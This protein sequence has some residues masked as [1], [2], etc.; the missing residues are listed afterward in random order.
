MVTTKVTDLTHQIY[1]EMPVY[2][3]TELPSFE[4]VNTLEEHG[5]IETRITITSHTGTHVDAPAHMINNGCTLDNIPIE[6]FI[7][8]AIILDFSNQNLQQIEVSDLK[9]F[10]TMIIN[11][12]NFIII[13]TGWSEYWGTSKYYDGFPY[14]SDESAAWLTKFGLKG[15]GIDA[16]SIDSMHSTTFSIHKIF[17]KKNMLIIE[18]LTNLNLIDSDKFLFTVMPLKTKS[19]DGSPARAAAI[20]L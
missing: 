1:P 6:N 4:K 13:K 14:L 16:I 7:G 15:I 2:P 17:M 9:K 11:N 19:A 5:F 18:N 20:S 10:E 12:V 8:D 3:G